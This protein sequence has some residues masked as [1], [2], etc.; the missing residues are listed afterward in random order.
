MGILARRHFLNIFFISFSIL[1][2]L[3]LSA[4]SRAQESKL[5]LQE[6]T[7][8]AGLIYNF[9]KYTTWPGGYSP[10]ERGRLSFC[11]YGGEPLD[12]MLAPLEG[13][14]A[15]Q[16]AIKIVHVNSLNE[17]GNCSAVFINEDSERDLPALR[18][19]LKGR[20]T[21]TISDMDDFTEMGGMIGLATENQRVVIYI[22]K[23]SVDSA[24]LSVQSRL[25]KLAKQVSE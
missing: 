3:L 18:E 14:T 8:K 25:L 11:F 2:F 20:P 1:C 7:I 12:G 24:G 21:L 9:L 22:N 16:A 4:P 15:Q 13:R 5:Q 17:T 10:A 19:F 23:K 6:Q